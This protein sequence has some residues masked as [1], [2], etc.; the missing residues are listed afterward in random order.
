MSHN[1]FALA[2]YVVSLTPTTIIEAGNKT[3]TI[4]GNFLSANCKVD[5]PAGLGTIVS[6]TYTAPSATTGQLVVTINVATV[7][8]TPAT[9]AIGLSNGGLDNVGIS[10]SVTLTDWTPDQLITSANSAWFK[11][12]DLSGHDT[13]VSGWSPTATTITSTVA[14]LGNS[15]GYTQPKWLDGTTGVNPLNSE[16]CLIFGT[17]GTFGNG[18][19]CRMQPSADQGWDLRAYNQPISLFV[20]SAGAGGGVYFSQGHT[21]MQN[22]Q[23]SHG[24]TTP[25]DVKDAVGNNP[26]TGMHIHLTGRPGGGSG[27][28]SLGMTSNGQSPHTHAM[29]HNGA[30]ASA[31]YS[32]SSVSPWFLAAHSQLVGTATYYAE[33]IWCNYVVSPAE[34][35]KL[36]TY[37]A[38]KYGALAT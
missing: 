16:P 10:M 11:A 38:D 15:S 29:Y 33:L 7:P 22:F 3:L 13:N 32:P 5:I 27:I 14:A 37:W 17:D 1:T 35:V 24:A 19:S 18:G 28:H 8:A 25:A 31:S 20:L 12:S 30:S 2:P 4:S 23:M 21:S 34:V 6:Q 36:E 9:Y 26:A